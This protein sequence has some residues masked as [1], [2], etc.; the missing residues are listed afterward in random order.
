MRQIEKTSLGLLIGSLLIAITTMSMYGVDKY[1][2]APSL[3]IPPPDS[4]S[5]TSVN[6]VLESENLEGLKR[7]CALWASQEDQT[8]SRLKFLVTEAERIKRN[9]YSFLFLVS[10]MFVIGSAHIYIQAR[11]AR[12]ESENAL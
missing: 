2:E 1:L 6:M 10:F 7:V 3:F 9:Y 4:N 5:R 8:K 12:K 11:G